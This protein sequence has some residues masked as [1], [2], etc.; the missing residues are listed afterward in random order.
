[1]YL[2]SDDGV[3]ESLRGVVPCT[4]LDRAGE[5]RGGG[6]GGDGVIAMRGGEVNA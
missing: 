4:Q 6:G 2:G 1:M 3:Y 5:M